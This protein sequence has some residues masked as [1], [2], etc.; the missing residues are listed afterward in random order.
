MKRNIQSIKLFSFITVLLLVAT[1]CFEH[2]G[3]LNFDWLHKAYSTGVLASLS[4]S[5]LVLIVTEVQAYRHTKVDMRNMMYTYAA[6][7]YG[8]LH[9]YL[10]YFEELAKDETNQLNENIYMQD[11][12]IQYEMKQLQFIQYQP[13]SKKDKIVVAHNVFLKNISTVQNA[14]DH[15]MNIK[16]FVMKKQLQ[17][18]QTTDELHPV[19]SLDDSAVM[20]YVSSLCSELSSALDVLET[21]CKQFE[22]MD[23]QFDF[24]EYKK[25]MLAGEEKTI[26]A[27]PMK[28]DKIQT[29][30]V[31]TTINQ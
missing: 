7:L 21:Y 22:K 3:F 19:I 20:A 24:T 25:A 8:L 31:F 15:L 2:V 5:F 26:P 28:I 16:L 11:Q 13:Y 14:V 27:A 18:V 1:Y 6:H 9:Y 29:N 23:A 30:E 10:H 12:V 17:I 4:A